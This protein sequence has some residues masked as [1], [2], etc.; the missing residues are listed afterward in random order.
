MKQE[1]EM[2]SQYVQFSSSFS[3]PTW[4]YTITVLTT[5]SYIC[6]YSRSGRQV[7]V[8]IGTVCTC[9]TR[10]CTCTTIVQLY[11][12]MTMYVVCT[13]L[14]ISILSTYFIFVSFLLLLTQSQ[15]LLLVITY[16][17]IAIL[18]ATNYGYVPTSTFNLV[19]KL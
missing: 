12:S 10:T 19:N 7:L 3:V 17:L 5:Y 4:L 18:N 1:R 9:C 15:V 2:Y 13:Y 16:L 11:D 6:T 14:H 8:C